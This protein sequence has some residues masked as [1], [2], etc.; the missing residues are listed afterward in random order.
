MNANFAYFNIKI[1]FCDNDAIYDEMVL[2]PV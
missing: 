2:E 1:V